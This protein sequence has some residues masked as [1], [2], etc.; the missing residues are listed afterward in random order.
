MDTIQTLQEEATRRIGTRGT[1]RLHRP[2]FGP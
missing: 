2:D 1:R